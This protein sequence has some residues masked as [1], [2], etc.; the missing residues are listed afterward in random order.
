MKVDTL[1]SKHKKYGI[2]E[3]CIKR[4]VDCSL[5]IIAFI[6]LS[7]IIALTAILVKLKLGGAYSFYTRAS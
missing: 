4:P 2:Y 7:P 6:V 3:K 1:E 5:A